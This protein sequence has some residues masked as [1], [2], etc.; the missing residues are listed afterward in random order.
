MLSRIGYWLRAISLLFS[1]AFAFFAVLVVYGMI[2]QYV[3]ELTI[4]NAGL[5]LFALFAGMSIALE[6]VSRPFKMTHN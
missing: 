2:K 4:G 6:R 1:V 3:A 5:I